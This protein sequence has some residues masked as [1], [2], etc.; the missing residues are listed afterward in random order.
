MSNYF[1]S[2]WFIFICEIVNILTP[3]IVSWSVLN[4]NL[5]Q[6]GLPRKFFFI[7]CFL[8]LH[9]KCN[10]LPWSPLWKCPSHP[11]SSYSPTHPLQLPS[12]GIT[13]HWGIKPS[14]DQG[15][16]L[17]LTSN[18]LCFICRWSHEFLHVYSLVGGLV[19]GS[20]GVTDWFILLFLLWGCKLLPL[21]WSFLYLLHKGLCTQSNGW[22]RAFT[23]E[24]VMHWQTLSGDSY[25]RF[26]SASTCWHLQ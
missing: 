22:L 7:R 13:L 19:S 25:I 16:L 10:P 5:I 6:A 3:V 24:H 26:L 21:L 11:P 23:S 8:Y 12:L 9:F 14:Q 2:L 4:I 17:L 20:S 18:I 15:L 1:S